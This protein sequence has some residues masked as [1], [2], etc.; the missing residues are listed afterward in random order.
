M[1][2]TKI[3]TLS[4]R[5]FVRKAGRIKSDIVPILV[6]CILILLGSLLLRN[7]GKQVPFVYENV[8]P[9]MGSISEKKLYSHQRDR[10][11]LLVLA[12]LLVFGFVLCFLACL[13]KAPIFIFH[14]RSYYVSQSDKNLI[15]DLFGCLNSLSFGYILHIK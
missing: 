7:F 11:P 6:V 5:S 2:D 13:M 9:L 3:K 14:F 4:I 8:K 12:A 1:I 10:T 15:G